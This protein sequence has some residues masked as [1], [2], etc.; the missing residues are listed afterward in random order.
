MAVMVRS[1]C[2]LSSLVLGPLVSS[3]EEH[4]S[5]VHTTT[6]HLHL[7]EAYLKKLLAENNVELPK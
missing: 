5:H 2:R 3:V 4:L 6:K 7:E 1:V